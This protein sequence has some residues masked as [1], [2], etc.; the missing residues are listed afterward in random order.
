MR[1]RV[2][3]RI[4]TSVLTVV[5]GI[6]CII[7]AIRSDDPGLRAISWAL[8]ALTATSFFRYFED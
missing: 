7:Y 5:F 8:L 3:G 6:L 1:K 4:V 2:I